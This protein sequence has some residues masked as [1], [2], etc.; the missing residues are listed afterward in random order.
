M[1]SGG[2]DY[3]IFDPA[4]K[5]VAKQSGG[6][7]SDIPHFQNFAD[8]IREGKSLNSPISEG[9]KSTMLCHLANIAFRTGSVLEVDPKSGRV[10]KNPAATKLWKREY[11]A[12]WEPKGYVTS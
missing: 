6:R 3:T 9:Q 10:L 1:L 5:E 7:A 4:G 2:N 12:G 11:R 8:A